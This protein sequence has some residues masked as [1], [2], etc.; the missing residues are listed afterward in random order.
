MVDKLKDK[1]IEL[2]NDTTDYLLVDLIYRMLLKS[3]DRELT[4]EK[5]ESEV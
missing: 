3:I 1:V 2:I 5:L 4:P